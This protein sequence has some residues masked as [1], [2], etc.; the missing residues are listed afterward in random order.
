MAIT[1]VIGFFFFDTQAS[2]NT[3]RLTNFEFYPTIFRLGANID[4]QSFQACMHTKN[5]YHMSAIQF[6]LQLYLNIR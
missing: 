4:S 6:G 5:P 1:V 3:H 2:T